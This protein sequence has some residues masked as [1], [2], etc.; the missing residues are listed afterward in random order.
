MR[1]LPQGENRTRFVWFFIGVG[2]VMLV[3]LFGKA[4]DNN[5]PVKYEGITAGQKLYALPSD[6]VVLIQETDEGKEVGIRDRPGTFQIDYRATSKFD[7]PV[8]GYGLALPPE[9][10]N[11]R[12]WKWED[13]GC[14]AEFDL[15]YTSSSL[16]AKIEGQWVSGRLREDTFVTEET[17]Y[18]FS[19][20][21][22][23]WRLAQGA[24]ESSH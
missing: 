11:D 10:A 17:E 3:G 7:L 21:N 19:S 15:R 4:S 6:L 20:D 16:E 8:I 14:D 2:V 18:R 23:G 9:S 13:I 24:D 12:V 1:V 22:G 5:L